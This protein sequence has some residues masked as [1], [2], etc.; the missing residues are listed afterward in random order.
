MNVKDD[1]FVCITEETNL[2]V[3]HLYCSMMNLRQLFDCIV[4]FFSAELYL[5][6]CHLDRRQFFSLAVQLLF[7]ALEIIKSIADIAAFDLFTSEIFD[8]TGGFLDII[9]AKLNKT[10][11]L[12]KVFLFSQQSRLLNFEG[13]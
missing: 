11:M 12:F 1:Y 2:L 4:Q 3:G 10:Q 7:L 8:F 5:R 13:V 6:I 9:L